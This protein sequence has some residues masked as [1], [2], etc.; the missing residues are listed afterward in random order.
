MGI[1]SGAFR[2]TFPSSSDPRDLRS[3]YVVAGITLTVMVTLRNLLSA[4]LQV[5]ALPGAKQV[6]EPIDWRLKPSKEEN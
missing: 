6:P 4:G 2:T 3:A 1:G 5:R